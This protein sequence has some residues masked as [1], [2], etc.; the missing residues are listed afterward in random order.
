MNGP[1]AQGKW[2]VA[3]KGHYINRLEMMAVWLCLKQLTSEVEGKTV[4][5]R[6]DN[7]S[8][9]HYINKQGLTRSPQ[10]CYLTWGFLQWCIQHK[11]TLRAVHLA[12]SKNCLADALSRKT[13]LP[14][15]WSLHQGVVLELSN[16]TGRLLINLF[17]SKDNF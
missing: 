3:E 17:G 6:L 13:F 11:V 1:Y 7:T 5:L 8:V 10:L 9:V 16:Q 12:G 15:E 14:V 4:L 2:S